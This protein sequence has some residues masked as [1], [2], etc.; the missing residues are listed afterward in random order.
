MSTSML[1]VA[2]PP[3]A[4]D[5]STGDILV[6]LTGA[7]IQCVSLVA[8]GY[9]CK[10]SGIF[11]PSEVS[12]L[13]AFVGRLSLPA[14]LF[15]SMATIEFSS[16]DYPLVATIYLTKLIIFVVV[17]VACRF[18]P[19]EERVEPEP[20][21]SILVSASRSQL[22]NDPAGHTYKVV[23]SLLQEMAALFTD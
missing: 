21:N 20:A 2:A 10:R 1:A 11:S 7:L 14:L 9:A 4:P 6:P 3:A 8:I 13:S 18:A 5:A 22:Y 19:P 16:V 17:V 12:G 23:H 15:L